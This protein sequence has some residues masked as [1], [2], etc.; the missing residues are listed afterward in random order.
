MGHSFAVVEGIHSKLVDL[1]VFRGCSL[2][3]H[4]NLDGGELEA[5]ARLPCQGLGS[6]K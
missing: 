5:S 6:R 4:Q 3:F 2:V 1:S